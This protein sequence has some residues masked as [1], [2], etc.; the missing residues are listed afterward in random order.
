M[1]LFLVSKLLFLPPGFETEI[2]GTSE[3]ASFT[4]M[5]YFRISFTFSRREFKDSMILNQL[6]ISMIFLQRYLKIS[7]LE[8]DEGN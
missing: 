7:S 3:I 2:S 4:G 1:K 5:G 6:K 8:I